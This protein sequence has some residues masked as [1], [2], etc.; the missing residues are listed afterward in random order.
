ML[1]ILQKYRE[2][3][4]PRWRVEEPS[5]Q[6]E[7]ESSGQLELQFRSSQPLVELTEPVIL[8]FLQ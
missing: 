7:G 1:E 2:R 8:T 5:P 6:L 3:K 4:K